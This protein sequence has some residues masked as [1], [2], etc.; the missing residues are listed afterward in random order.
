MRGLDLRRAGRRLLRAPGFSTLVVLTLALGLGA[1]TAIFSLFHAV[2]L[3]PLPLPEPDQ[4][5]VLCESHP[6]LEG[7]CAASPP[8]AQDWRRRS[9]NLAQLGIARNHSFVIQAEGGARRLL[10]TLATPSFF[11]V[12]RIRPHIGRFLIEKDLEPGSPPVAVLA[13]GTWQQRYDGAPEVLG[14]SLMLDGEAHTIVGVLP[15]DVEI[16]VLA[17][18]EV[19]TP[20]P[21]LAEEHRRWRGFRVVAR[22]QPEVSG[23]RV[24]SEL[25]AIAQELARDHP[26]T[27]EGWGVRV[28]PLHEMVVGSARQPLLIFLGAGAL[29]LLIGCVNS[30]N[31]LLVRA[32]RR[33]HEFAVRAAMGAGRGRLIGLLLGESL[34]LA[35]LGGALGVALARGAVG[36][37]VASA[38]PGIP[39]LDGVGLHPGVLA[40]AVAL[41][42]LTGLVFGLAPAL[43]TTAKNWAALL[44]GGARGPSGRSAARFQ[45]GL[46]VAEM[47]LALTLLLGAGLLVRSFFAISTWTGGFDHQGLHLVAVQY[48]EER[49]REDSRLVEVY[50][51][52]LRELEAL[53]GVRSVGATSTGPLFGSP[54]RGSFFLD[55]RE[56]PRAARW[57]NVSP[58][59]LR[60]LGVSL[61]RGRSLD[62]RDRAGSQPVALVNETLARR[63]WPGEAAVGQPVRTEWGSTFEVVGVVADLRPLWPETQVEP[64]IYFPF[65]QEPRGATFYA[66]RA[67]PG[68]EGLHEALRQRLREIE[69]AA[70]ISRVV[71]YRELVERRLARPTFNTLLMGTFAAAALILALGGAFGVT[72]YRVARRTREI[73]L[74]MALGARRQ[75]VLRRVILHGLTLS[76]IGVLLGLVGAFFLT[77]FL[78]SMLFETP[79]LDL[80][81]CT[82]VLLFLFLT[83]LLAT[84]IPARRAARIEPVEALRAE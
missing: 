21:Y 24:R 51:R 10:G 19:W 77:R 67:D 49:Y 61:I 26:E 65:A 46:V 41:S 18:A 11:E 20:L 69:P 30:A 60:T 3:R 57:F 55:G 43:R 15:P 72:A 47:A 37:L 76:G 75:D 59:Y 44:Q 2:I 83:T 31:L 7:I 25:D 42:V 58:G 39:R 74:R 22:L 62:A 9:R 12:F 71:P 64:E 16:P 73:G 8:N 66:V 32:S 63:F 56:E 36:V 14:Q 4:L 5:V 1:T 79:P 80:L 70:S 53:P 29:V 33:E 13:H 54:E 23:R 35:G 82:V 27:N 68:L 81:T 84:W 6:S 45:S 17:K 50:R 34:L 52:T 48:P 78:A 28:V 40:F 38:P